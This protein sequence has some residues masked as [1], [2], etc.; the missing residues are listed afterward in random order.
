MN[1][2]LKVR[3]TDLISVNYLWRFVARGAMVLFADGQRGVDLVILVVHSGGVLTRNNMAAILIH[4]KNDES[5]TNT[6]EYLFDGMYPFGIKVFDSTGMQ[7]WPIIC[8]VFALASN[9]CGVKYRAPPRVSPRRKPDRFTAYDFWCAG[10]DT[11]TSPL[12]GEDD[13]VPYQ[14]LLARTHDGGQL[15]NVRSESVKYS[16]EVIEDKCA[17]LRQFDPKLSCRYPPSSCVCN[18]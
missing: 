5:F 12:I 11:E 10:L 18:F 13:R 6:R 14:H 16:D 2:V 3:D 4:V 7:P 9:K 8:M 17:L 15:Y 1:H